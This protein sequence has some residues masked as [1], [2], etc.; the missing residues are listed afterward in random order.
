M[1]HGP[2][3]S[4]SVN[5]YWDNDCLGHGHICYMDYHSETYKCECAPGYELVEVDIDYIDIPGYK[6]AGTCHS[7]ASVC[8]FFKGAQ[9]LCF[10]VAKSYT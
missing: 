7:V 5:C 4:T 3:V 2:I 1:I 8:K 9:R 6:C 10:P